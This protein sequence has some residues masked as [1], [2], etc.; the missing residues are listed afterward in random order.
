MLKRLLAHLGT[1]FSLLTFWR[2]STLAALPAP[3]PTEPTPGLAPPDLRYLARVVGS[4]LVTVGRYTFDKEAGWYELTPAMRLKVL[5]SPRSCHFDLRIIESAFA[6]ESLARYASV[7]AKL[8][9]SIALDGDVDGCKGAQLQGLKVASQSLRT[10]YKNAGQDPP[11]VDTHTLQVSHWPDDMA[12]PRRIEE[13]A[14][15]QRRRPLRLPTSTPTWPTE[16]RDDGEMLVRVKPGFGTKT[17]TPVGW[18]TLEPDRWYVIG[19][20][21]AEL[22]R[23]VETLQVVTRDEARTLNRFQPHARPPAF[24][25]PVRKIG[26]TIESWSEQRDDA[27]REHD[28]R[29]ELLSHEVDLFAP[30]APAPTQPAFDATPGGRPDMLVRIKPS[31]QVKTFTLLADRSYPLRKSG[32]W[33]KVSAKVADLCDAD[34]F[35]VCTQEQAILVEAVTKH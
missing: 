22:L 1:W 15:Q 7:I 6:V 14:P 27:K 34:T 23:D 32:G 18:H 2:R 13:D 4:D 24:I 21:T 30:P 33:Y 5:A 17:V 8:E 25:P 26:Q 31:A 11:I 12:P 35:N 10:A 29:V 28:L 3:A 16:S 9:A 20:R 19:P